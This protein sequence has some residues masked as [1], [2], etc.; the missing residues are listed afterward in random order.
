MFTGTAPLGPSTA[1]FATSSLG[2]SGTGKSETALV[3]QFVQNAAQF[4]LQGNP[5]EMQATQI[6]QKLRDSI[7]N[8]TPMAEIRVGD[9]SPNGATILAN[10]FGESLTAAM[11][12]QSVVGPLNVLQKMVPP[13]K[14]PAW[15][16]FTL[17]NNQWMADREIIAPDEVPTVMLSIAEHQQRASALAS[18]VPGEIPTKMLHT[19]YKEAYADKPAW[20]SSIAPY[21][22]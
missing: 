22:N 12:Q 8:N 9:L 7:S 15:N 17:V 16:V 4:H 1:F 3:N 6:A 5:D 19:K 10:A 20:I 14:N 21:F 13:G 11:A 18:L 2:S